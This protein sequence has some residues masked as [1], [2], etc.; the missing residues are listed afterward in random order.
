MFALD[1]DLSNLMEGTAASPKEFH[2]TLDKLEQ[3]IKEFTFEIPEMFVPYQRIMDTLS[4]AGS[5]VCCL[6]G[7]NTSNA[8]ATQLEAQINA[9]NADFEKIKLRLDELLLQMPEEEYEKMAISLG[10]SRFY[11]DERRKDATQKLP[12]DKESLISD[13]SVSGFHGLTTLYYTYM[14]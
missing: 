1:W 2:L 7:E 13:L 10:S 14:G 9:I 3:D 12:L 5:V 4:E 8:D 11:L 6:T